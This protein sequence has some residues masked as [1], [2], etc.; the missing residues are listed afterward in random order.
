LPLYDPLRLLEE[1]AMVDHLSNGRLDLGVGRGV[2]PYELG[3][4]GADPE[5]SRAVF[6]ETLEIL[7]KGFTN[8]NLTHVGTTR[9]SYDGVP[10]EL[11]PLQ[12]PYPPLWHATTSPEGLAW[13]ATHGMN[14][15]GLGPAS[16]FGESVASYRQALA[17]NR[18]NPGRFNAHVTDPTIGMMRQVIIAGTDAE[19][20]KLLAST[21]DQ[22]QHS[23]VKLWLANDDAPKSGI[24][25]IDGFRGSGALV[26]GSPETVRQ[27]L[28]NSLEEGDLNYL[29][30]TFAWGSISHDDVERSMRLFADEV[31]PHL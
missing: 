9:P 31:M 15:M 8:D 11:R 19:A 18:D 30:I 16:L 24:P 7:V 13:A 27:G 22:W 17:V 3:F 1:I 29:A 25:T 20:E 28:A 14:L 6:E 26:C 21:F 2:S 23:F 10:M 12:Q 4:F 5:T